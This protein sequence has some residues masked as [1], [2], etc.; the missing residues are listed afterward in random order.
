MLSYYNSISYF[1]QLDAIHSKAVETNV[2]VEFDLPQSNIR[3]EGV[4]DDVNSLRDEINRILHAKCS[5][6]PAGKGR[7]FILYFSFSL[8]RTFHDSKILI[9]KDLYQSQMFGTNTW[10]W[11]KSRYF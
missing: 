4:K 8:F 7:F 3:L 2:D 9:T 6:I 5:G 1:T 10:H 11:Y